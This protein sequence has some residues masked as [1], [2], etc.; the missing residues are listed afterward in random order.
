MMKKPPNSRLVKILQICLIQLQY[1]ILGVPPVTFRKSPFNHKMQLWWSLSI[2]SFPTFSF[3]LRCYC[4]AE[5]N[6]LSLHTQT[7]S[8]ST[9][10]ELNQWL[11]QWHR[12]REKRRA[13]NA[14]RVSG[15]V[16]N[17]ARI[18]IMS[19]CLGNIH[20]CKNVQHILGPRG[21]NDKAKAKEWAFIV[22]FLGI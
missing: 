19:V 14:V 3:L 22:Q 5:C 16:R 6:K 12:E 13:S 4:V 1:F 17:F 7:L 18:E 11:K 10:M 9:F 20:S 8:H 15:P 2:V 21:T